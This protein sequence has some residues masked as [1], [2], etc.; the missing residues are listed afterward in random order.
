ML[1]VFLISPRSASFPVFKREP[2]EPSSTGAGTRRYFGQFHPLIQLIHK[3][4]SVSYVYRLTL[5][6]QLYELI[7]S[8][9]YSFTLQTSA[10]HLLYV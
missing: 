3:D 10:E 4:S 2:L 6:P 9:A 1:L 8:C 7:G 5:T